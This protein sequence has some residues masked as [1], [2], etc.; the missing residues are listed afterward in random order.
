MPLSTRTTPKPQNPL[1]R[2]SQGPPGNPRV[3]PGLDLVCP[4]QSSLVGLRRTAK[5]D[6][7]ELHNVPCLGLH[8][9]QDLIQLPK[10]K[11]ETLESH[12]NL[13][14]AR[15]KSLLNSVSVNYLVAA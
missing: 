7:W 14:H 15:I 6:P 1:H 9:Q 8:V 2:Y 11:R 12:Q 10:Q 13:P 3:A 4:K 5:C